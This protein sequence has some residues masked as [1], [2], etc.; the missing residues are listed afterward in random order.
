MSTGKTPKPH[1][2][3][4]IVFQ[5]QG[6]VFEIFAREVSQGGLF[7]FIEVEEIVFGERS[8]LVVDPSEERL[9][10]EFTG[11]R[12]TYIP[13]HC[14][15]RIDQVEREGPGRIAPFQGDGKVTSFPI[16]VQAPGKRTPD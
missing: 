6:E 2:V 11:V 4:K 9:K 13:M 10:T 7:G 15:I 14:V 12:R 1:H 16:P 3:Y 8:Q 5:Q